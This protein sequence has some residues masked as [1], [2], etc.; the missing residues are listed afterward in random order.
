MRFSGAQLKWFAFLLMV[1]EHFGTWVPV[2]PDTVAFGLK[3]AG[4]LVAPIFAFLVIEG[5]RHT[6][7]RPRY[8]M[9]IYGAGL[10]MAVGTHLLGSYLTTTYPGTPWLTYNIF[11]SLAFGVS[12]VGCLEAIWKTAQPLHKF[13]AALC[14]PVLVTGSALSE[15]SFLM[16]G[17]LLSFGLFAPNRLAQLSAF[18]I[19][20]AVSILLLG[21]PSWQLSMLAAIIP[22]TLYSGLAGNRRFA[23]VFYV[24]YPVHLWVFWWI[25]ALIR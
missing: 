18:A 23:W 21:Y 13:G 7:N 2:L 4:R 25:D 20:S 1:A 22:L 19:T 10:I 17:M 6:S 15:G 9:R 11:L 24:G 16:L 8:L 12:V 5:W 14:L 3:I